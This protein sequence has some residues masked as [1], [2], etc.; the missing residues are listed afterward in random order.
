MAWA[1]E[2]HVNREL[3]GFTNAQYITGS[4]TECEDRCLDERSFI[5]R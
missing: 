1:F 3:R 4:K 2:R 5:C